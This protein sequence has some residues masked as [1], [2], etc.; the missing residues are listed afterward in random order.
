MRFSGP[1][2][3]ESDGCDSES[4]GLVCNLSSGIAI[5]EKQKATSRG[6]MAL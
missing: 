2:K 6:L 5:P 4:I 1:T 3:L